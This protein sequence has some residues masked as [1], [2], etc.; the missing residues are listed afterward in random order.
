MAEVQRGQKR[1]GTGSADQ[2]GTPPPSSS[3]EDFRQKEGSGSPESTGTLGSATSRPNAGFPSGSTEQVAIPRLDG[4]AG[5]DAGGW[6]EFKHNPDQ[7][8]AEKPEAAEHDLA[9]E[10]R[11]R[12]SELGAVA[13]DA[14]RDA[15]HAVAEVG[16][17]M[18][19]RAAETAVQQKAHLA[20]ELSHLG[21]AMRGAARQLREER[22]DRVA[23]YAEVA[24]EQVVHGAEYLRRRDLAGLL[25][26]VESFA[27]RRPEVFLGGLFVA[28]LGISRFLKAS[29]HRSAATR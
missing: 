19:H 25:T 21:S 2:C 17:Q 14:A 28:G 16:E 4:T 10:A 18:R 5:T 23:D 13:S 9:E 8:V 1:P 27:R 15:G 12:A 7:T 11:Q 3:Q 26:D 20:D 24:A 22:E 29:A 6:P